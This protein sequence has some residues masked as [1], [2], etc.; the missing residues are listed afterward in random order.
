MDHARIVKYI[1]FKEQA[2]MIKN[3]TEIPVAYIVQ[4]LITGGELY[5]YVANTG[6]FRE[7]IV[8]FYSRQ[9]LQGVI[10][11]HMKGFSHRDLKCGNVLLDADYNLKICDMGF[12]SHVSGTN[13]SGWN[14]TYVGTLGHMSPQILER[15]AYKGV[16]ADLFSLG[17]IIFILY[18]GYPP[19]DM[20]V[21]SDKYYRQIYDN[22]AKAFW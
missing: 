20:A 2:M 9:L 13:R 21:P 6:R 22:N 3:G 12:A 8:R 18:V 15:T 10:H 14:Q 1:D 7:E 17:V 5:E 11:M 19:F 4:E 16:E